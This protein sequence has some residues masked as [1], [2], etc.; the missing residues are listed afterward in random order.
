MRRRVKIEACRVLRAL[1]VVKFEVRGQHVR[2]FHIVEILHE[3][4]RAILNRVSENVARRD[5][6]RG[7]GFCDFEASDGRCDSRF[8]GF[9]FSKNYRR[10]T[11]KKPNQTQ[12]G[13]KTARFS[14]KNEVSR[15]KK[16][17]RFEVCSADER[18]CIE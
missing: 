1:R 8:D 12:N 5:G 10:R 6:W 13:Q 18:R 16:D 3:A 7:N 15:L 4:R 14:L 9:I 17:C 11:K 2:D